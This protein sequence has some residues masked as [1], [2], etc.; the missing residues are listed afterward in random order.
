MNPFITFGPDIFAYLKHIS[1]QIKEKITLRL[2]VVF[3]FFLKN[4]GPKK[5]VCEPSPFAFGK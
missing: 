5:S 3:D 4:T 1:V 2:Q